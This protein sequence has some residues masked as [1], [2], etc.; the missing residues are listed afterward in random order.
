MIDSHDA[1]QGRQSGAGPSIGDLYPG[2]AIFDRDSNLRAWTCVVAAER[3]A[4]DPAAVPAGSTIDYLS[5]H[6]TV[7]DDGAVGR[8]LPRA[9]PSAAAATAPAAVGMGISL[10]GQ[11]RPIFMPIPTIAE[12]G[13]IDTPMVTGITAIDALT[14]IGKGQNMLLIGEEEGTDATAGGV[15]K[16]GWTI[17][18]LRN[19]AENHRTSA[20]EADVPCFYALTSGDDR[21]RASVR[22]GIAAAGLQDDIVTVVSSRG[23]VFIITS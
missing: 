20:A 18:L 1:K 15:N 7:Q 8:A 4:V 14:P 21:V 2:V 13:L 3:V 5:R 16:R 23:V 6:V 17:G 12:I 19:V 9:A 10:D 22:D 11:R